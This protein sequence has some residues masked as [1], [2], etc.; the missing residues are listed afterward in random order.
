LIAANGWS[1]SAHRNGAFVLHRSAGL[2]HARGLVG[3]SDPR[4]AAAILE[5]I[6]ARFVF[7]HG[8]AAYQLGLSLIG[9][10]NSPD[11]KARYEYD[12]LAP[13]NIEEVEAQPSPYGVHIILPLRHALGLLANAQSNA[14]AAETGDHFPRVPVTVRCLSPDPTLPESGS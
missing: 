3:R 10:T 14:S 1:V 6:E 5:K 4:Q 7:K 13:A 11:E 9:S 8:R 12:Y 2:A